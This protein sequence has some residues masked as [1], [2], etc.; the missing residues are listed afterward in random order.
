MVK[1]DTL[2]RWHPQWPRQRWTQRSMRAR[3]GR[4]RMEA[5]IRTLVAQMATANPLWG[6]ARI[7]R[8]LG[9]LG[10]EVYLAPFRR[11]RADR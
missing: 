10:I 11:A 5:A 1:P 3:P 6:A 2:L 4:P 9:K 7:P 8:K